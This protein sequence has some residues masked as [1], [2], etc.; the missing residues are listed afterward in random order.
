MY[1]QTSNNVDHRRGHT[2]CWASSGSKLFAKSIYSLDNLPLSA[3]LWIML[4]LWFRLCG[5][6]NYASVIIQAVRAAQDEQIRLKDVEINELKSLRMDLDH[7]LRG[8]RTV[9]ERVSWTFHFAFNGKRTVKYQN[10]LK[11]GRLV[12]VHKSRLVSKYC[13]FKSSYFTFSPKINI[14]W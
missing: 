14:P 10:S 2:F 9:S 11:Q 5:H 7:E 6:F 4:L 13:S 12:H 3:K 8:T 1:Y